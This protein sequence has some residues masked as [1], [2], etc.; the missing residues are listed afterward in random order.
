MPASLPCLRPRCVGVVVSLA[1]ES[2][3]PFAVPVYVQATQGNH[4]N[5]D[6]LFRGQKYPPTVVS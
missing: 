4:A 6:D 5:S 1:N 2:P 3:L